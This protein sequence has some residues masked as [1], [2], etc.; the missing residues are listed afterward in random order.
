MV[1]VSGVRFEVLWAERAAV[2]SRVCPKAS[3][4]T[5]TAIEQDDLARRRQ[6]WRVTLEVPLRA[7]AIVGCGE[8]NDPGD[9]RVE[10]LG[11]SL[12]GAT[13]A[14][15]VTAFEQNDHLLLCLD[16]PVLQLDQLRLETE[17]LAEVFGPV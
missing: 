11:D 7:L 2:S 1:C 16:N 3:R 5:P 4:L 14:G 12:D 6:V 17:E 9:A 8:G 15:G 10:A 13:L